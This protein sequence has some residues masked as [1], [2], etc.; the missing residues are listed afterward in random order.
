M[1]ELNLTGIIFRVSVMYLYALV[2]V[3][4]AG[5]QSIGQ[6]TAMD[7]VVTLIIGDLFDDVFWAEVPVLQGMVAFVIIVLAHVLVTFISSRNIRFYRLVTSPERVLVE[8]VDP[9]TP[10]ELARW[11]AEQTGIEFD[12]PAELVAPTR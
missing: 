2:L 8:D 12:P 4:I 3:R 7:F 5:K 1:E 6:L 11:I 10:L 9:R